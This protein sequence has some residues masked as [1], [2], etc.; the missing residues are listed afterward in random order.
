M[1]VFAAVTSGGST[2]DMIGLP[3]CHAGSGFTATS[4]WAMSRELLRRQRRRPVRGAGQ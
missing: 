2:S 3:A 1:A 4:A